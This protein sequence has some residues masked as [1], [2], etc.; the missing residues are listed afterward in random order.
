VNPLGSYPITVPS[1]AQVTVGWN[2]Q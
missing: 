2:K 1:G